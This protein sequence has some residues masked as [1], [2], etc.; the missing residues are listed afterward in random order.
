LISRPESRI[1]HGADFSEQC[2]DTV[3]SFFSTQG[4]ALREFQRRLVNSRFFIVSLLLHV[5]LVFA[6]GTTVLFTRYVEPPD[7]T[8]EEG[9]SFVSSDQPAQPPPSSQEPQKQEVSFNVA[10]PAATGGP[11]I[12]ALTAVSP[13]QTAFSVPS[14]VAPAIAPSVRPLAPPA[15]LPNAPAFTPGLTREIATG[16]ASFTAG[17][18]KGGPRSMGVPLKNR[19]FDFTAYLAQYGD[20]SDVKRGGDWASTVRLRNGEI[21]AGSLPNLLYVI[22][23][24]SRDK[25]RAKPQPVPLDLSNW[26]AIGSKKPPFIF[27]TGHRDFILTETEVENLQHYIRLGGCIWGDSSLP[28]RRSRFDVAFRREMRRV[29]PDVDKKFEPLPPDHAIFT[30][31]YYPEIREVPPGLNHYKEP[32]YALK[33]YGEIAV[34]YTANDYGDMWQFGLNERGEI[35]QRKDEFGNFVALNKPMW[36][37]RDLYFRNI[38]A[39]ALFATY[40]FGTNIIVHLLTRWED[41]VRAVPAGL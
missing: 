14:A 22:D 16:I 13:V 15:V 29:V 41:K 38:S 21:V 31:G 7:F 34:L 10:A 3:A 11:S 27:F 26:D 24:L 28:G 17:W 23:K 32:V 30:K 9:G 5:L 2:I 8:G 20:A 18:S 1:G 35:D 36:D 6:L 39:P 4:K 25:I 33:V 37:R 19:E 12:A 40:K